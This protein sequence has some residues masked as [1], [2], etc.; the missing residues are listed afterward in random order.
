MECKFCGFEINESFSFCPCCGKNLKSEERLT[1]KNTT[2][3]ALAPKD[4]IEQFLPELKS[5]TAE[6]LDNWRLGYHINI[7]AYRIKVK[8]SRKF[9]N[10]HGEHLS[11]F[12]GLSAEE[13]LG[14]CNEL[15]EDGC[16]I[17]SASVNAF[18]L[19]N[20]SKMSDCGVRWFYTEEECKKLVDSINLR[21]QKKTT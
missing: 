19:T 20:L 16:R 9:Y 11:A 7:R 2:W 8:Y 14:K 17:K 13:T 15:I 3:L 4:K 10:D 18:N 5:M 6:D 1:L 12:S 21:L